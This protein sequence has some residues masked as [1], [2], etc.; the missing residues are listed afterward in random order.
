[1]T[2]GPGATGSGDSGEAGFGTSGKPPDSRHRAGSARHALNLA[3]PQPG[4]RFVAG[5]AET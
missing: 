5:G 4:L 3:T 1:M 2:H